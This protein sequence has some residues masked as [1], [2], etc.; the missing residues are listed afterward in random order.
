MF[1]DTKVTF[2]AMGAKQS[3]VFVDYLNTAPTL[4]LDNA[5]F[6]VLALDA[7]KTTK[8]VVLG[9]RVRSR[10]LYDLFILA[11]THGYSVAQILDDAVSYGTNNDP[12]YYKAVLRGEIPLDDQDEGLEPVAVNAPLE[13]IYSFFDTEISRLEVEEAARIAR[14]D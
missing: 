5:S 1:G 13:E 10:D 4:N 14:G 12:E 9:Q 3:P 2:F 8:A 7:L 6:N 11:Q